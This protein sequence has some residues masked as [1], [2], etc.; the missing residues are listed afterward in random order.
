MSDKAP[1]PVPHSQRESRY[2]KVHGGDKAGRTLR[3][4]SG[5]I[6]KETDTGA[7]I[8]I[9]PKPWRNKAEMK[10]H[11]RARRH[12]RKAIARDLAA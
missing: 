11:K 5:T 12:M 2:I 1:N 4:Q 9:P 8:R 7:H 10:A 3:F 6:H